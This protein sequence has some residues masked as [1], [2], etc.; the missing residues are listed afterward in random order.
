MQ[1]GIEYTYYGDVSPNGLNTVGIEPQTSTL[2]QYH[3]HLQT[4]QALVVA[5]VLATTHNV[6]HPYLSVG[7]GAGFNKATEFSAVTTETDS[8]NLTPVFAN[9]NHTAFSYS[10]GLGVDT[11][12]R[13][14]LRLGLG[15]RFSGFGNVSLGAGAIV[16]NNYTF[17]VS[18]IPSIANVYSNQFVAQISYVA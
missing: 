3:Y 12:I 1:G 5:K 6:F 10:V 8:N 15:Y 17:P 14:K 13:E 16:I 18:F 4:Q 7:L 9:N 11:E 2:Y